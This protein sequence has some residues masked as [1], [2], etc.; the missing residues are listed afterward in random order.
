MVS[1]QT[2]IALLLWIPVAS[3]TTSTTTTTLEYFECATATCALYDVWSDFPEAN[4]TNETRSACSDIQSNALAGFAAEARSMCRENSNSGLKWGECRRKYCEAYDQIVEGL[5]HENTNYFYGGT[6]CRP[7]LN[8][9]RTLC[10]TGR[11]RDAEAFCE[12]VC[13]E[14]RRFMDQNCIDP[15][16]AFLILGR[17]GAELYTKHSLGAGCA[18]T[19][20]QFMQ[21]VG[22]PT[23]PWAAAGHCQNL[24]LPFRNFQCTRIFT[25]VPYDPCPWKQDTGITNLLRCADGFEDEIDLWNVDSWDLC[26]AHQMRWQCPSNFPVMCSD[27][28][29]CMGGSDYCCQPSV[30]DCTTLRARGCS[31]VL[32]LELPEWVGIKTSPDPFDTGPTTTLSEAQLALLAFT[33]TTGYPSTDQLMVTLPLVLSIIFISGM[34]GGTFIYCTLYNVHAGKMAGTRIG[35]AKMFMDYSQ[36]PVLVIKPSGK[37]ADPGRE[38][39]LPHKRPW[40]QELEEERLDREAGEELKL[41]VE[42]A[43]V[44]PNGHGVNPDLPDPPEVAPLRAALT[45][46][47]ERGLDQRRAY[48]RLVE[49]GDAW[50]RTFDSERILAR[51]AQAS[52][53][54]LKLAPSLWPS[55]I[56]AQNCSKGM[57]RV[58]IWRRIE[59]LT[60]A[61][62]AAKANSADRWQVEWCTKLLADLVAAMPELPSDRCVPDPSGKGLRLLAKGEQRAVFGR[63]GDNY[64]YHVESG[65]AGRMGCMFSASA[66]NLGN[67]SSSS[68]STMC[69]AWH[70]SGSCSAG[71]KCPFQHPMRLNG[72]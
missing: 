27:P 59:D 50:M 6:E 35:I 51:A 36:D 49:S 44:R 16:L 38:A 64:M 60:V 23:T 47:R 70:A 40:R 12:C 9:N 30:G 21:D 46:A 43:V 56:P 58:E 62:N 45:T 2:R 42:K 66:E 14:F 29:E 39:P 1:V 55:P 71:S 61:L 4:Q 28:L 26:E 65:D 3:Q 13:P 20:C 33:T 72:V 11:Y 31:P 25:D 34:V 5:M 68:L 24:E 48:V 22:N 10:E 32:A 15:I 67:V 53:P 41:R 8:F 52:T 17:R 54:D 69:A 18:H 63:T 37:L 7:L 19:L 57:V